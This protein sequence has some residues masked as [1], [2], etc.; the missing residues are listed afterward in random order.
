MNDEILEL[1][2]K[3]WTAIQEGD[4]DAAAALT[5]EPCVVTGS[6]GAATITREQFRGMMS[7]PSWKVLGFEFTD[8]HVQFPVKDVAVIAYKVHEDLIVDGK[9]LSIDCADSSVWIRREGGWV[10]ALHTE[11]LL[12]DAFGR[13]KA[14]PAK[15]P[16]ADPSG[17]AKTDSFDRA[18]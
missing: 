3:F 9:P 1:E 8:V 12:G 13:D 17:L 5:A 10:C 7:A 4:A 16:A 18:N 15:A 2:T 11:S 6:Q 14:A